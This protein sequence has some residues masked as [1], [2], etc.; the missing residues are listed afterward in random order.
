MLS[1]RAFGR[2]VEVK[3]DN[4]ASFDTQTAI[5]KVLTKVLNG[6]LSAAI[7]M[8][9]PE[10]KYFGMHFYLKLSSSPTQGMETGEK[11]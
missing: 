2:R 9:K 1:I 6:N 4:W 3:L 7:C 8:L 11:W 5:H 10:K